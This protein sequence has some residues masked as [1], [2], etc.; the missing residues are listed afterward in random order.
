MFSFLEELSLA[1]HALLGDEQDASGDYEDATDDVEDRGTDTTGA[2]E[3]CSL[4]VLNSDLEAV[5]CINSRACRI[6]ILLELPSVKYGFGFYRLGLGSN[7]N[8][9]GIL[10]QIVAI[11]GLNFGKGISPCTKA[12]KRNLAIGIRGCMIGDSFAFSLAKRSARSVTFLAPLLMRKPSMW[13][14]P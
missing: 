3:L 11:I 6:F 12:A 13:Y 1:A 4:V 2:G 7:N 14:F 10:Q 5:I 8:S 9:D